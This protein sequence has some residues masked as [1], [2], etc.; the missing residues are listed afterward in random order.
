MS[1][2]YLPLERQRSIFDTQAYG[3]VEMHCIGVGG[4]GSN[5]VWA[6]VSTLGMRNVHVY[7]TAMVKPHN[8]D[9][10]RYSMTDVGSP[11]VEALQ[12]EIERWTGIRIHAHNELVTGPI[13][14]S[15]IVLLCVHKN[16]I[17]R[18]VHDWC[19]RGN[20]NVRL[21]LDLRMGGELSSLYTTDPRVAEQERAWDGYA[22]DLPEGHEQLADC[23]GAVT[24][25]LTTLRLGV[26][27]GEQ[28]MRWAKR[29]SAR[30]QGKDISGQIPLP[31]LIEYNALKDEY[32]REIWW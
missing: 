15:G 7:D 27:T 9:N 8:G 25:G 24:V 32:R 12:R 10:Q 17:R 28:I 29:E 13:P 23:G 14:M 21:L 22:K 4:N 6:V 5:A 2:G 16:K 26:E 1:D 19:I 3:D 20:P 31:F 11:K 30:A 18:D